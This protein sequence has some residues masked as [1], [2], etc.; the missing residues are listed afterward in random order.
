MSRSTFNVGD[1]VEV[2]SKEE[3]LRTLD[4]NARLD[5]MPFMPEMFQYCG[6]RLQVHK[7][8]HK[9]CDPDLFTRRIGRAVHLQT[10]CDG[11]AHGDC[12]AGCLLYWKDPWLKAVAQKASDICVPLSGGPS[13]VAR[14]SCTEKDVWNAIQIT[15]PDSGPPTYICQATQVPA[16][17]ELLKW[18]DI[19]HYLEDYWSRNVSLWRVLSALVYSAYFHLSNAGIGIGRAMRWFYDVA[20]PLW[21]GT[22]W[23]RKSGL[24][25]DGQPTPATP[26]FLQPGEVVR[27]KSYEEILRTVNTVSRNRGLW[28]DA[29][30]VPYCGRTFRVLRRVDRVIDEKTG[31]MQV[32]KTPC[33]VLDSVICQARYSACRMLCPKQTYAYWREVWLERVESGLSSDLEARRSDKVP[34]GD[35]S[36]GATPSASRR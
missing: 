6:S 8:A 9:T 26:L 16:A 21:R 12:Q 20:H 31:K 27:V 36:V 19:R 4:A 10:R 32:M 13:K 17:G 30:L 29:E 28:W 3:I 2:L 11:Q 34:C 18:W 33:I 14:E 35:Q 23:P 22:R 7:S 15:G 1:W 5:G 25:P 24:I